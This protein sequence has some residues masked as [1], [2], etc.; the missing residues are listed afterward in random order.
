MKLSAILDYGVL[1]QVKL[2]IEIQSH[3]RHPNILPMYGYFYDDKKIYLVLEYAPGGEV[4]DELSRCGRFTPDVAA[5][6]ICEIAGALSY[7][8]SKHIIHRDIKPEN[9]V[10]GKD[11][12]VYLADFGWSVIVEDDRRS[13]ICGTPD[14][15]APE[16]IQ[17]I[18]Y[19]Y[20]VDIWALGVLLYE[21]LT[22]V[23]PFSDN[24][25]IV[26]VAIEYPPFVEDDAID[27]IDK[28]LQLDSSKRISLNGIISH[29][30]IKTNCGLHSRCQ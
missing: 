29:D 26:D 15:L 6:Y 22:G 2:E 20:G 9:L 16:M 11:D 4:F 14:Y 19:D 1:N 8:H 3:L 30:F 24:Q 21:F 7:L 25:K 10:L 12:Q 27:L 17:E 23:A 18:E 13:T 28:M 5:K